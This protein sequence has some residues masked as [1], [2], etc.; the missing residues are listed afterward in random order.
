MMKKYFC[1]IFALA[2]LLMAG[3]AFTACSSD[4]NS[5]EQPASPV[6]EKTYTLTINASKG[7]NASTRALA[8]DGT[9]LVASWA[10]GDQLSVYNVTKDAPLVGSLIASNA[11][12][13]TA[14]FSG[15]LT[16]AIDV[17]DE[18]TLS[19]HQPTGMSDYAAQTG[20]LASA[21]ERDYAIATI[22]VASV[23]GN[24]NITTTDD[25][26]FQTHTSMLKLTLTDGTNKINPSKLT[27]SAT[28]EIGI[29]GIQTVQIATFNMSAETYVA[30]GD[31]ILYFALPD[32]EA[33]AEFLGGKMELHA[34]Y[35]KDALIAENTTFAYTATTGSNTYTT[36]KDKGYI[37]EVGKYYAGT[38]KMNKYPIALSEVTDDYLGSVITT[39]GLVYPTVA[40]AT[41]ASKTAEAK[42]AYV[43]SDT[44]VSGKTRG[45]ALALENEHM[46]NFESAKGICS[47]KTTVTNASSWMLPSKF[48]WMTMISAAGDYEALRDGF[49]DVGGT[50]MDQNQYWSATPAEDDPNKVW[51]CHFAY[52]TWN[53]FLKDYSDICGRACIAF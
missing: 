49:D 17:D 6:G 18:L 42:I 33:V 31:G 27:M 12:G 53:I 40:Y 34:G 8:L 44:D 47:S 9:K 37:F 1:N 22:T 11:N 14:T 24:G 30:N 51:C 16:G 38:L 50:N 23:D 32:V 36:I 45:L 46:D 35:I 39:D 48:Q 25:A 20:T 5:I 43:G 3:A 21:A 29:M 52:G 28:M 19:Y 10:N 41:A 4:D 7:A 15:S 26:S 2:A 13:L